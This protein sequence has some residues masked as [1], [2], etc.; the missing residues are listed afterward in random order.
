MIKL[1]VIIACLNEVHTLSDQLEALSRQTWQDWEVI[2]ADNGS[3][4]GTQDLARGFADRL[5]LRVI[6]ASHVPG[7]GYARN[8]GAEAA[9]GDALLFPDADDV[10]A[11]G[12]LQ[13]MGQA[14]EQHDFVASKL[15]YQHLNAGWV[16]HSRGRPQER[17]LAKYPYGDF[18][19][20]AFGTSIGVKR[21]LHQRV[22]GFDVT[23]LR[24]Q[25]MEYCW[26]IQEQG[27]ALVY[28]PEAAIHYRFRAH[29]NTLHHQARRY[30]QG[31]MQIYRIY[32]NRHKM[33]HDVPLPPK[34]RLD[35]KKLAYLIVRYPRIQDEAERGSWTW[36][37]GWELGIIAGAL[38]HRVLPF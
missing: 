21:D 24:G 31:N 33:N 8:A 17:A 36:H 12:W 28:V 30:A 11:E 10:V 16:Y 15:E 4:D 14:L 2:I 9:T 22:G 6:D 27:A 26:R 18:F 13:H 25:D 23:L 19:P 3:T 1:S 20:H 32:L 34:P 37:L 29:L 7:A 5:N 38:Q 35:L